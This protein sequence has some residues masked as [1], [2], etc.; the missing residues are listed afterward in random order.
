[1]VHEFNEYDKLQ[2]FLWEVQI[3]KTIKGKRENSTEDWT[4]FENKRYDQ[5][6]I[7]IYCC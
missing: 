3:E 4:Y 6:S 1:M 5:L 7:I 2:L